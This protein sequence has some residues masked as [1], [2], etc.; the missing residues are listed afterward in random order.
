[1]HAIVT[2]N[3]FYQA[4]RLSPAVALDAAILQG[5]FC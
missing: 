5:V 4:V 1:V 3:V 2:R